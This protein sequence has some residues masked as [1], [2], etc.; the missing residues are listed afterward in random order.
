MLCQVGFSDKAILC[1]RPNNCCQQNLKRFDELAPQVCFHE[2]ATITQLTI[3]LVNMFF[4]VQ[5]GLGPQCPKCA[6]MV[7]SIAC[8]GKQDS[9]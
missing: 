4:K 7:S 1:N 8:Q 9:G 5:P 2:R 6:E 3:W